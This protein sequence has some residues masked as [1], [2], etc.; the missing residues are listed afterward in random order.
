MAVVRIC[1]IALSTM[2]F[3][4]QAAATISLSCE[5]MDSNWPILELEGIASSDG[6]HLNTFRAYLEIE[7]GKAIEFSQDDVKSFSARND[8]T[9][10]FAKGPPREQVQVR[11]NLRRIDDIQLVGM[12]MI[13][14]GK[15][16]AEGRIRCSAG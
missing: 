5:T 11:V 14:E 3:A 15:M 10:S 4:V 2:A 16:S 1:L 7:A 8:I 13:R 6:K 12:F 9:L